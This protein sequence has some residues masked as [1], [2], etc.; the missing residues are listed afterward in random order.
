MSSNVN[1]ARDGRKQLSVTYGFGK[2]LHQP[3]SSQTPSCLLVPSTIPISSPKSPSSH[4]SLHRS[5]HL[6]AMSHL[7]SKEEPAFP[8]MLTAAFLPRKMQLF[9]A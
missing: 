4:S 7:S 6:L 5:R 3:L 1:D 2:D 9:T 8:E